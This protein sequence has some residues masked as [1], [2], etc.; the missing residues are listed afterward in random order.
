MQR[1]IYLAVFGLVL[2]T[3]ASTT[4]AASKSLKLARCDGNDRRM[5]NAHGSILPIVDPVSGVVTPANATFVGIDVFPQ[6]EPAYANPRGAKSLSGDKPPAQIPPIG[7][8]ASPK[9]YKSC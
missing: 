1:S 8:I 5:A 4:L 6:L 3:P 7:A 9:T 2:I